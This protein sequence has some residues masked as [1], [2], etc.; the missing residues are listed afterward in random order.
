MCFCVACSA[1]FSFW[2][3][4]V[5]NSLCY[6]CSSERSISTCFFCVILYHTG[7]VA[8]KS[9]IL[10]IWT[11]IMKYICMILIQ[12]HSSRKSSREQQC[13]PNSRIGCALLFFCARVYFVRSISLTHTRVYAKEGVCAQQNNAFS[14]WYMY[15]IVRGKSSSTLP[16]P[17]RFTAASLAHFLCLKSD[18]AP[19]PGSPR[20]HSCRTH[21]KPYPTYHFA[22]WVDD[23]HFH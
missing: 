2:R 5:M 1:V 6:C 14:T 19:H 16:L 9:F 11:I 3:R 18:A 7:D 23:R 20:W 12:Q 13:A 10:K 22:V 4:K 17:I 8:L 15:V 21:V